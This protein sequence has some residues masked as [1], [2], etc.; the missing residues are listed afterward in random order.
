MEKRSNTSRQKRPA[1]RQ[2]GNTAK[3][4]LLGFGLI[5]LTVFLSVLERK[6]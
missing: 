3:R 6:G 5:L 2:G 4:V 1:P